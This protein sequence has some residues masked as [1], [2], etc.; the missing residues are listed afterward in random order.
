MIRAFNTGALVMVPVLLAGTALQGQNVDSAA[1]SPHSGPP[2]AVFSIGQ[3]PI[4]RQQ[5]SAQGTAYA[6][7]G[8]YGATFTYGVF[9]SFN[10]PP[11]TAFNPL[12]GVIGATVE[13]YGSAG[14]TE[15]IGLRAMATSRLFATSIG[16]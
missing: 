7:D 8:R 4:W 3:P 9:H 5:I 13:A 6:Q 1:T 10:K 16:A 2:P 12:L 14:G 15:D 11:S